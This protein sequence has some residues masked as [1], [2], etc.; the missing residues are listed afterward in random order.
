VTDPDG[1]TRRDGEAESEDEL[2]AKELD[3]EQLDEVSG[4]AL[5]IPPDAESGSTGP[6]P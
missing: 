1:S 2:E 5:I 3:D 6:R 4:G